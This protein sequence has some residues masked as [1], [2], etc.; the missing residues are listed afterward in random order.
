LAKFQVRLQM[1]L[2][3]TMKTNYSINEATTTLNAIT[4][5]KNYIRAKKCFT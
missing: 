3:K 5:T 1:A 2:K 4:N